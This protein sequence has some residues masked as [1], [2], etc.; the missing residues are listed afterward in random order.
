MNTQ[1]ITLPVEKAKIFRAIC[2]ESGIAVQNSYEV[3]GQKQMRV[4]PKCT[5]ADFEALKDIYAE[6]AGTAIL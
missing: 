3:G 6:K 5:P 4:A 2:D 1:F